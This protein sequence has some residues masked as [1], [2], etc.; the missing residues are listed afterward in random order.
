MTELLIEIAGG[1]DIARRLLRLTSYQ[2]ERA[3]RD[4]RGYRELGNG[5]HRVTSA[6]TDGRLVEIIYEHPA[7]GEGDSAL[8]VVIA[9]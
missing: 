8:V 6:T 9:A 2:I 4:G 3:I 5:R 1:A 7:R